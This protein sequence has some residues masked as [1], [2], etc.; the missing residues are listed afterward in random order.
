MKLIIAYIQKTMYVAFSPKIKLEIICNDKDV[1][2][3]ISTI[4]EA[5]HTGKYGDGKIYVISVDDV[6]RIR[7]GE[8]GDNAV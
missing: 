3:I 5:A 1:D 4:Q 2:M 6:V 7:T 8:Q